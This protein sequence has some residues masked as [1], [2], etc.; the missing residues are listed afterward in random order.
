MSTKRER[1]TRLY[2]PGRADGA[3]AV[4]RNEGLYPF[5][6][7]SLP[8]S[9]SCPCL[10]GPDRR[11]SSVC[12]PSWMRPRVRVS[13]KGAMGGPTCCLWEPT[14]TR[15]LHQT[16][17]WLRARL[18]NPLHL[19]FIISRPLRRPL[20]LRERAILFSFSR[21]S[22]YPDVLPFFSRRQDFTGVLIDFT[23]LW[24]SPRARFGPG[25]KSLRWHYIATTGILGVHYE[26]IYIL[27]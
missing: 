8:P 13:W 25:E 7:L 20:S 19:C 1:I 11:D 6:P 22:S 14:E 18:T 12:V 26:G 4:R 10:P 16:P 21:Y 3:P 9:S 2:L 17:P 27:R 15:V 23:V 5:L 24:R